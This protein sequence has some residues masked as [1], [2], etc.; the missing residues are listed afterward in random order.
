[1]FRALRREPAQLAVTGEAMYVVMIAPVAK[2]GGLG[3][4]IV[5][6][7]AGRTA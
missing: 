3:D 1:M 6:G 2:T 4:V 7:T 5:A